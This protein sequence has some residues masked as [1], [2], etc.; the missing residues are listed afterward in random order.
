MDDL[1]SRAARLGRRVGRPGTAPR[2]GR[3]RPTWMVA[4]VAVVAGLG[5]LAV[6]RSRRRTGGGGFAA[7][8]DHSSDPAEEAASTGGRGPVVTDGAVDGRVPSP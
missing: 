6:V 4:V 8:P 5:I 3:R 7:D 2:R 1:G